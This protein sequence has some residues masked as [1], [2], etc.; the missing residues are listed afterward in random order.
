M[1][2]NM[3][4]NKHPWCGESQFFI[5]HTKREAHVRMVRRSATWGSAGQT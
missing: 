2:I 4:T 5:Y 1:L 3:Q